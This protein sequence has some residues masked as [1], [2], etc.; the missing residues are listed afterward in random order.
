MALAAGFDVGGTQIKFGLLDHKGKI[1]FQGN[2]KTPQDFQLFGQ[3]L[4]QIWEK[5]KIQA[6]RRKIVAVGFGFPGIFCP[7]REIIIQSPNFPAL[8]GL[9]LRPFLKKIFNLPFWMDNDANLA[10]YGEWF[11]GGKK[12]PE[13]LV[14]LTLGTG[15]GSGIILSGEIWHGSLGFAAEI[16]HLTV[17]PEG[18]K[19]HCGNRGCLET[20]VSAKALV[21][22]YLNFSTRK[23]LQKKVVLTAKDVALLARKGDKAARKS[24]DRA[25]YFLGIALGAI[26][27]FLNPEVI[28]IG[29][30]VGASG[31][32]LLKP[33]R[34]E[35][36][37]HCFQA[38]FKAT[39]IRRAILGNEAGFI[40]AALMAWFKRTK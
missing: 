28:V 39:K 38:A 23:E 9:P 31:D 17:N 19:C 21:R 7:E 14:L 24:F 16:G 27:N 34:Q 5:M 29:G 33:A 3:K 22:H 1:I 20:E 11:L 32:L 15:V 4:D 36:K 2:E 40:G 35:A 6:G 25:A 10:A 13:S 12:K 18:V 8:D 30:G 37:K 26:I